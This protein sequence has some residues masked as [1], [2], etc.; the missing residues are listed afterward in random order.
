MKGE[1]KE[2]FIFKISFGMKKC[3][4]VER[5][6]ESVPSSPRNF[7]IFGVYAL[8]VLLSRLLS[9]FIKTALNFRRRKKAKF[10]LAA[11]S[12]ARN[13]HSRPGVKFKFA[14]PSWAAPSPSER[15]IFLRG[16][17]SRVP[18]II[19]YYYTGQ[20]LAFKVGHC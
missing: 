3:D 10:H 16:R 4:R 15:A 8:S 13:G 6:V 20:R 7:L 17:K 9:Q 19:I 11:G 5:S 1:K 18:S 12:P 2:E 14:T